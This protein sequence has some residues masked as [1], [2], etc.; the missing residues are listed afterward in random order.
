M[1]CLSILISLLSG[2]ALKYL[3]VVENSCGRCPSY[4]NHHQTGC[5][6]RLLLGLCT[7]V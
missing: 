2:S 6:C 7:H 3:V 4:S 5:C 1:P